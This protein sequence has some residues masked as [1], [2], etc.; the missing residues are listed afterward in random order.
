M[1][2]NPDMVAAIPSIERGEN[3]E[4]CKKSMNSVAATAHNYLLGSIDRA[5]S[6][7]L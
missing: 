2:S 1:Q 7:V 5:P 6:V 4:F 3:D